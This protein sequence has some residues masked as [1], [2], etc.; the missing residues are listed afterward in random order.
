MPRNVEIKARVADLAALEK[1]LRELGAA[2]P[3]QLEQEDLFFERASGRL[4]LRRFADGSGELIA[5]ARPDT[6]GPALSS[7]ERYP[8]RDPALLAEVLTPALGVRGT[9]R[10]TRRLWGLEQTR[11]HLDEVE[12]L[13]SFV[14]LE[15]VLGA[16]QTEAEGSRV[17]RE[18]MKALGIDESALVDSA[19]VDL[20]ES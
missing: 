5:Y 9:V 10:K 16:E 19:Y 6:S 4:K 20:L 15:V 17:A 1:R 14:E 2:G 18:L 7:Y 13:G 11:V 3:V 12:G 8:T